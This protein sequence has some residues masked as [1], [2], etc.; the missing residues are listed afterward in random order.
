MKIF[1]IPGTSFSPGRALGVDVLKRSIARATGIPTT[2]QGIE[3]INMKTTRI[4][5]AI[6]KIGIISLTATISLI[7]TLAV[8][9]ASHEQEGRTSE[10]VKTCDTTVVVSEV[11][12]LVYYKPAKNAG[13]EL[14]CGY[15]DMP[16]K[17]TGVVFF[18]AAAYTRVYGQAT[19]SH[20]LVGGPHLSN[21]YFDGYDCPANS[22]AFYYTPADGKWGFVRDNVAEV[23]KVIASAHEECSGFCQV[24]L[25]YN[26]VECHIAPEAK[27]AKRAIRRA[28]C[29][30]NDELYVIDSKKEVSMHKFVESLKNAGVSNALYMDMGS[31][32][33][34]AYRPKAEAQWMEIYKPN[35]RTKYCSNYLLFRYSES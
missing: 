27:P 9:C 22:G 17:D 25:L 13:I 18:A 34:S 28:L 5:K 31:M 26:G 19:F 1:G 10:E 4:E 32:K 35:S 2:R 21:G 3:R 24:M 20:D 8:S 15:N 12:G 14:C 33:Y 16:P 23:F 7:A 6:T 11:D 29:E 30:L